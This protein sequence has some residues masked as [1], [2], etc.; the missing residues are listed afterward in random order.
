M[1]EQF[2]T[3]R[4]T[5]TLPGSNLLPGYGVSMTTPYALSIHPATGAV[6]LGDFAV[7][8]VPH[9]PVES[10]HKG[11]AALPQ[12]AWDHHNGYAWIALDIPSLRLDGRPASL[13]LCF[14]EGRL[15]ML[16]LGVSLPD[17]EDEEGWPTEQSSLRQVAFL[18]RTLAKQLGVSMEE[19]VA[20]FP[21]GRVWARFDP[22]G[23]MAT[24]GIRYEPGDPVG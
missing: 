21:W 7:V 3:L 23:F 9:M 24:A 14:F 5:A 19:G 15:G 20:D 8:L 17:D 1:A 18:R 22:K 13:S 10:V 12:R 6:Q 2:T 4:A 16:A 11:F